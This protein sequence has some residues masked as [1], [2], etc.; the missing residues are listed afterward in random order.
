MEEQNYKLELREILEIT[1]GILVTGNENEIIEN[2]CRDT[3]EI[4]ENDVYLGIKSK[5]Q[6]GSIYFEEA[7]ENGAKG[8]ILQDI[9]IT[10]T[11][12]QK[13]RNKFIILVEDTIK[14]MQQIATYKREKYDIPV[15]AITGSV[16]KN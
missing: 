11:Q 5:T 10:E 15:I 7:F 16:R 1:K 14:A 6:N 12:K 4:K 8:V 3:R 2:F 13:Y 9:E